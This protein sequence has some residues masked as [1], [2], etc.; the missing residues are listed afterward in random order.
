[1]ISSIFLFLN[2]GGPELF[3][4]AI[5]VL[6]L[7]GPEKLPGIARTMGKFVR[8]FKNAM[9]GVQDEI[10]QAMKEPVEEI[11][12]PIDSIHQDIKDIKTEPEKP[13]EVKPE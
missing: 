9:N 3:V 6:L 4:I 12:K 5:A 8:E 11:K 1:M 13:K 10:T 2:I 7:F